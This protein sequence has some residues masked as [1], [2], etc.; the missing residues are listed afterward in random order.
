MGLEAANSAPKVSLIFPS[1]PL[2][3]STKITPNGD[4]DDRLDNNLE[5]KHITPNGVQ[6]T[7]NG[8]D[9]K[10]PENLQNTKILIIKLFALIDKKKI[11]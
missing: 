6:L 2:F 3:V 4:T 5:K 10:T 9:D 11:F 1:R 8:K 7:T